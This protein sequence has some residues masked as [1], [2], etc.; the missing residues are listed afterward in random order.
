MRRSSSCLVGGVLLAILGPAADIASQGADPL[1]GLGSPDPRIRAKSSLALTQRAPGDWLIPDLERAAK[2]SAEVRAR[3][4][5]AL[6]RNRA[7]LPRLVSEFA[8]GE[9]PSE[10][11]SS[12]LI[13]SFEAN[14]LPT[15]TDASAVEV[16]PS[17]P[18]DLQGIRNLVDCWDRMLVS[19]NFGLPWILDPRLDREGT[20]GRQSLEGISGAY[21]LRE[22]LPPTQRSGWP[23]RPGQQGALVTRI[24]PEGVFVTAI[25]GPDRMAGLFLACLREYLTG[26]ADSGERASICLAA[27]DLPGMGDIFVEDLQGPRH[28]RALLGLMGEWHRGR[29]HLPPAKLGPELLK[30]FREDARW[31]YL[32]G[33]CLRELLMDKGDLA[34]WYGKP[35]D[36]W[37]EHGLDALLFAGLRCPSMAT[38]LEQ[39]LLE[40]LADDAPKD[41]VRTASLLD[42]LGHLDG[43]LSKPVQEVLIRRVLHTGLGMGPVVLAQALDLLEQRGGDWLP[44]DPLSSVALGASREEG[45]LWARQLGQ[46]GQRGWQVRIETLLAAQEAS[47]ALFE[48]ASAPAPAGAA[49]EAFTWSL[50][51]RCKPGTTPAGIRVEVGSEG[52]FLL[53]LAFHLLRPDPGEARQRWAAAY[54]SFGRLLLESARSP[55]DSNQDLARAMG[56]SLGRLL[57]ALP[58]GPDG[59]R[60]G[61]W[62]GGWLAEPRTRQM[63][64]AAGILCL[65]KREHLIRDIDASMTSGLPP[66]EAVMLRRR[67]LLASRGRPAE[68]GQVPVDPMDPL[69]LLGR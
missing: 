40:V 57:L 37:K 5:A 67:L 60:A 56:K 35:A 23:D 59:K 54:E 8:K 51:S 53:D 34:S 31:R 61:K 46:M 7:L 32:T 66:L 65:R 11:L 58:R 1:S 12:C 36:R 14:R 25:D 48:L 69:L 3:F 50:A 49:P 38:W 10:M 64:L 41:P 26:D 22:L 43:P 17:T 62:L 63:G 18:L 6:G 28:K 16:L 13:A 15:P 27:L 9:D 24:V 20:A 19:G 42:A 47:S 39:H 55:I 4:L 33:A 68:L 52:P 21:T 29:S 30:L 2:A 44:S 45:R